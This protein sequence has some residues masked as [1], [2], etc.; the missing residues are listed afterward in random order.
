M[1]VIGNQVAA[2]SS[3]IKVNR[4][5]SGATTVTANC[6]AEVSYLCGAAMVGSTIG[7]TGFSGI[8]SNPQGQLINRKFGPGQS[9]PATFTSSFLYV[10]GG[11][12]S[13]SGT[14]TYT[15]VSGVEFIN[16]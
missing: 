2:S 12:G 8:G 6:Y 1:P 10:D 11:S 5:I 4:A 13:N 15:L 16:S 7:S 9:I 3:S 14:L